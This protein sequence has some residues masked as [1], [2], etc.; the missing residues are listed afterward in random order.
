MCDQASKSDAIS[1]H[2]QSNEK[3]KEALRQ[4]DLGGDGAAAATFIVQSPCVGEEA[5]N[6]FGAALAC[7]RLAVRVHDP[8]AGSVGVDELI[9]GA[10]A[11][12]ASKEQAKFFKRLFYISSACRDSLRA[13][14]EGHIYCR[15]LRPLTRPPDRLPQRPPPCS[16]V[17]LGGRG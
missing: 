15:V 12:N 11:L 10:H 8:P 7:V 4:F 9:A 2:A 14:I 1:I 3:V 5:M 16:L 17:R 13:N 6:E